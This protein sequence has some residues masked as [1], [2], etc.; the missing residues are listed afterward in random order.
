MTNS[1]SAGKGDLPSPSSNLMAH[2][3]VP[4]PKVKVKVKE[5]SIS[6]QALKYVG[7][8]IKAGIPKRNDL[9][10]KEKKRLA[11]VQANEPNLAIPGRIIKLP[12]DRQVILQVRNNG[13]F[14]ITVPNPFN[15]Q[16]GRVRHDVPGVDFS[17]SPL[18]I[19]K[20]VEKAASKPH[21]VE[22]V[23]D[24]GGFVTA[25]VGNPIANLR[26]PDPK[27]GMR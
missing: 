19:S 5:V 10:N 4:K 14:F 27:I 12:G 3:P 9:E 21:E 25:N 23:F 26:V 17:N 1:N 13:R 11:E 20:A 22:Y 15:P 18:Q 7:D 16:V 6:E 24:R 2:K 8:G